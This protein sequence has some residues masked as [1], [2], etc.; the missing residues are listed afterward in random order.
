MSVQPKRSLIAPTYGTPTPAL[1]KGQGAWLYDDRDRAYLDFASGIAV[2]SLGHNHPALTKAIQDQ[3]ETLIHTSN[4]YGIPGQEALAEK[5]V[6]RSFADA[7]FFCNSGAEAME[8]CLKFARRYHWAHDQPQRHRIISFSGA[9]HGR[10]L[11]T[12]A[13]G[14]APKYLESFGPKV[15]GFDQVP[16][17]D[18]S[19]AEAAITDETAALLIEPIQGEGGIRPHSAEFMQSVRAL[20]DQHGL[21]LILD[22]VQTGVGRT[23]TFW[24]HEACGM[25]PDLLASAK[26]L[27][28][29]F[30][31]GACLMTDRVAQTVGPG[32]HGTTYGGNPLAMAAA[33]AVVDVI[34]QPEFLAEVQTKGAYLSDKLHSLV[35]ASNKVFAGTRG[36]GLMQCLQLHEGQSVADFVAAAKD[37][38]LLTVPAGDQT[39]RLLPPLTIKT[40]EIDQALERLAAAALRL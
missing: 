10:T 28:G 12:I 37:E 16:Y 32:V 27:G 26:G 13:A 33:N 39:V 9:F 15:S 4:L 6:Q 1:V 34:D 23:G 5:L 19:A 7:V 24:A 35:R 22:E 14:G 29:G 17:G 3:A 30:P 8:A 40:D 31:V 20:A 2:T 18:L 25:T 21:L 38:G 36:L 11:A